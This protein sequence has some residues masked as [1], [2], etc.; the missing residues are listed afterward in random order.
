MVE[1]TSPRGGAATVELIRSA[2]TEDRRV[3]LTARWILEEFDAYYVESRR[4]PV[5]AKEAF[6]NRD[7]RQSLALSKRRLSI[8]SE[9]IHALGPRLV[10]EFPAL[11]ESEQLWREVET[12]YLPLIEGRYEGDLAFAY[13]NSVRRGI[14]QDEWTP[15]EYAFGDNAAAASGPAT[16]ICRDFPGGARVSPKTVI[17][18]LKIPGFTVPYQDI[19]EDAFLIAERVNETLGLDDRRPD[20]IQAIQMIDAGFYRNRGVYIVGRI[21]LG[22]SAI[23]PFV[24]ALLNDEEGIYAD[25]VLTTEADSHNI[26][27]STLANFN[28]TNTHYHELSAFLHSTMPNRPLGLHYSTIGFNHVGKVAVMDEMKDELARHNE[29]FETA[30]GFRGTVA[31]GFSAP[32][33][34]YTLKVIRD[35]PTEQ[36]KWGAFGGVESVLGKYRRVHEINR[37]GSM[38]DNIIY[39]NLRLDRDWFDATLLEELLRHASQSVSMIEGVVVLKHLIVQPKMIPLPVFL[40]TASRADAETAIINLGHCI[41]NNAAANVF[42]KDLDGRNYGVSAYLKVYLFDYDALEPFTEVKIRT[43]QDRIDGEEDIPD[44]FFED[45]VVFLPEEAEVG[46]RIPDRDLTRLFRAVHGDLLTTGYW[47]RIQ[48][49]LLDEKVPSIRIYPE[50]QRLIREISRLGTYH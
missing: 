18:I 11:A 35:E 29:R 50:D 6:E 34:S 19:D 40:E 30:V 12:R 33:S 42:N 16:K 36:Y 14:Y 3:A 45:G 17:E 23:R 49:D 24:I 1:A 48:S 8:Y 32:S 10:R 5:L 31:I 38:L 20:A 46:L 28:V 44:W 4:I 43:N 26:F 13:I 41:K 15:V 39:Y 7:P 27:S 2:A 22:E 37:T 47:E 25:A 21:V 9:S